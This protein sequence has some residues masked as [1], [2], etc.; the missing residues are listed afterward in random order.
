LFLNDLIEFLPCGVFIDDT[1]I[2]AL[3]YADD[4]ALIA[5]TPADLQLMID[6]L[7]TYCKMWGLQVNLEKTA[8]VV[9]RNHARLSTQ[10]SFKFDVE[11]ISIVNEYKYL[12]VILCYN[13]SF[14]KHLNEK[15]K[16]A[17][18][19]MFANWSKYIK[20]PRI[21]YENKM[22]IFN[23]CANS[24]LFYA[25]PIWGCKKY[26]QVDMLLRTFLKY[27]FF[28]PKNTPNYLLH[29]ET[30]LPS[31][32]SNTLSLHFTYINRVLNMPPNRLPSKLAKECINKKCYW[33]K[34][35]E[36]LCLEHNLPELQLSAENIHAL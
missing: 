19:S 36:N 2:K 8:V 7:Y 16:T 18:F 30:D 15:L 33:V 23:A 14:N 11:T 5:E 21:S 25:A 9:F 31:Q 29:L 28:L 20:N 35:W 32:F 27:L 22:K 17:K 13:L 1:N 10:L 26:D 34:D 12:G 24:I 4:L 3:L 6:S